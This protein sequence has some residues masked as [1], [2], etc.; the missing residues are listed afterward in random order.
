MSERAS[1]LLFFLGVLLALVVAVYSCSA[2]IDHA[3]R[4]TARAWERYE[5]RLKICE[6]VPGRDFQGCMERERSRYR[7]KEEL[8]G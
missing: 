7:I 1:G 2:L 6:D 4:D 8:G 5:A 3:D